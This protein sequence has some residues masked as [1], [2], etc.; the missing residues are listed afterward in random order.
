MPDNTRGVSKELETEQGLRDLRGGWH[1]LHAELR[2]V[3]VAFDQ[4][5]HRR[6]KPLTLWVR[7]R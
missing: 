4:L 1:Q 2:D 5:S 3:R 7:L 6:T